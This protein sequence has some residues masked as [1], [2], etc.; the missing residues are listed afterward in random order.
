MGVCKG[1]RTIGVVFVVRAHFNA[2]LPLPCLHQSLHLLPLIIPP[3][4]SPLR[5]RSM[6][7]GMLDT[8]ARIHSVDVDTA[9]LGDYGARVGTVPSTPSASPS[10]VPN[11][12]F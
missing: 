8:L 10:A 3:S 11:G 9:G 5:K 12:E 4:P 7:E 6:Y 1:V 2:C